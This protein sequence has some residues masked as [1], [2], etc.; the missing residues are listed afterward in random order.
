VTTE[1]QT[2][3]A[4]GTERKRCSLCQKKKEL[5]FSCGHGE[6]CSKCAIGHYERNHERRLA[7]ETYPMGRQE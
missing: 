1:Q 3:I 4:N 2:R 6:Y 5:I 7:N